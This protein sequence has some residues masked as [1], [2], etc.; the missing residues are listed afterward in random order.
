MFYIYIL[1]SETLNKYY[2]GQSQDPWKRLKQHNENLS[3][4]FTGKA[5]DW[6]LKAVFKVSDKRADAIAIERFIKNQKS[7]KFIEKL[8]DPSTELVGVLAQLI[9]VPHVR[10]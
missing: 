2:I 4:K 3:D 8:I 10:D 5:K 6:V 1:F 9:R 7:K